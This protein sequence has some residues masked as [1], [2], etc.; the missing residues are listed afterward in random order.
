MEI[1]KKLSVGKI[2]GKVTSLLPDSR[3]DTT[4][5]QLGRV[6]GIAHGVKTGES[7]FGPWKALAGDFVFEANAGPNKD[8]RYR[9]G[10]LFVPDVILDMVAPAVENLA[11][12]A[13]VEIAFAI[14]AKN[15]ATCSVGY[16]YGCSFLI[17]P[18][19]NDPMTGLLDRA[20]PAPA[21]DDKA[22]EKADET[23]PGKGNK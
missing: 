2:V 18:A 14:T 8:K 10:V 20:L 12:G 5:V 13:S 3:T 4:P 22:D 6:V 15:D 9:S 16:S 11:K 19:A 17:E 23:R 21:K 1:V 7:T